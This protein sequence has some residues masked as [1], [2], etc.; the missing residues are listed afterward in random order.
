MTKLVKVM[1]RPIRLVMMREVILLILSGLPS[2]K[3]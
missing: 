2:A 3:T 1:T